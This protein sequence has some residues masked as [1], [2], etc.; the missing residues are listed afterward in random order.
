[1]QTL[2]AS[3]SE[4]LGSPGVIGA[5]LVDAVTGLTYCTV[6]DR[7]AVG[8]GTELAELANLIADSFNEAGVTGELES[9]VVTSQRRC[10]ITHMVPR[11]GDALLLTA[12]VD[13][14]RTNLALALRQLA[15]HTR[16]VL[17]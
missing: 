4:I 10:H 5:A 16:T 3:L 12:A 13:R 11:Q 2:E 7:A 17:R 8:D 15:D 6:G 14:E 1:M 9:V